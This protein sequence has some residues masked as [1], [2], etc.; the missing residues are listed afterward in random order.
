[1]ISQKKFEPL[2]HVEQNSEHYNRPELQGHALYVHRRRPAEGYRRRRL[3][4]G[5]LDYL[6]PEY[7]V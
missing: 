4:S 2:T 6:M 3:Y 7:P 1:M 5:I